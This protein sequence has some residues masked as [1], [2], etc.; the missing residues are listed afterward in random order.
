MLVERIEGKWI[1][2]FARV[3]DL[4]AVDKSQSAAIL[5]ETQSR[6]VNV[7]LAELGLDRLGIRPIHIVLPTLRQSAPVPIRSTGASD[8]IAGSKAVIGAL[9]SVDFVVDCT[10]EGL[11]HAPELPEILAGGSRILMVSNEHPEALERLMPTP[12]LEPK[13]KT[14][15][16]KLIQAK[17]MRVTSTAGTDIT[18]DV[19]EAPCGG[20][21][22]YTT[23][24]STISHWPGGLCLAF[25]TANTVNGTIVMDRGDINLTFKRYVESPIT[26]TIENDYIVEVG[27]D[28]TDASLFRSYTDAWNDADAYAA[29][30]IGWGMNPGARWDTLP[31]YDRSQTNGTEQRAFAGNF[32]YST[33]A[34]EHAGRHTLGHF[35]LPMRNHTVLLDDESV[36]V[37]GVLQGDLA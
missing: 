2:A 6:N 11:L 3:F 23:R 33:G 26:L 36:V 30:H 16:K 1:E 35:D 12:D 22:G 37:D 17:E 20:G 25:P 28:G 18:V 21:W 10:V 14:G 4:C 34:N 13:V 29:S 15:I 31:L 9:S 7:N 32:L 8:A 24:P 19:S 5:S 27:G